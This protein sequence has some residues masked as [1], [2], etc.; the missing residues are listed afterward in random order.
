MYTVSYG[1]IQKIRYK[2]TGPKNRPARMADWLRNFSIFIIET[3][4][5]DLDFPYTAEL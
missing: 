1:F 4:Y 3:L 5:L 2:N